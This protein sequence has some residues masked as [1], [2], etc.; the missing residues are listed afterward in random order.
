MTIALYSN[1]CD[2]SDSKI[3]Y[4]SLLLSIQLGST[5]L[6]EQSDYSKRLPLFSLIGD[7]GKQNSRG[8]VSIISGLPWCKNL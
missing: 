1:G 6:V 2:N 8:N 3:E 7:F 5:A 4:C